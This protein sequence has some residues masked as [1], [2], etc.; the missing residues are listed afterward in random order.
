VWTL[1]SL[2]SEMEPVVIGTQRML[3]IQAQQ[4]IGQ[5]GWTQTPGQ[6]GWAQIGFSAKDKG[7]RT[8]N[9]VTV[10]VAVWPQVFR[11]FMPTVLR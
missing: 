5:P 6:P 2:T 4:L 11:L 3:Q 8:S 10:N 1:D 7:G 9:T